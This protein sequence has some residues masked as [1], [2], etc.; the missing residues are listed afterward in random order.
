MSKI[1]RRSGA[2]DLPPSVDRVSSAVIVENRHPRVGEILKIA[3]PAGVLLSVRVTEITPDAD[4]WIGWG[5]VQPGFEQQLRAAGVPAWGPRDM[6]RIF[7]W[8]VVRQGDI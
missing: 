5:E 1:I 6:M 2:R 4:G 8:Q 7:E 3:S